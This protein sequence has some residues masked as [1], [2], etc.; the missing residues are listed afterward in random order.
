MPDPL[1]AKARRAL[2]K[3]RKKL[4]AKIEDLGTH[5]EVN[6]NCQQLGPYW[7]VEAQTIRKWIRNGALASFRVGRSVRVKVADALA[8]ERR[9][10]LQKAG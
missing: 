9:N 10:D 7:N 5:P 2:R 6:V 4:F 8:F 1:V 3:R